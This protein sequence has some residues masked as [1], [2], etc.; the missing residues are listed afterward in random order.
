MVNFL[1]GIDE[2]IKKL[3]SSRQTIALTGAGISTASGI[4]DFRS[5]H[6]LWNKYNPSKYANINS[7]KENPSMVWELALILFDLTNKS[8]PNNAHY[9]LADLEKAG[10]LH[11][12]ITQNIDN[13]HQRAGS[14]NVIDY[15]GSIEQA[16]CPACHITAAITGLTVP[17]CSGCG[18]IMKPA[19]TLFGE[20]VPPAAFL[21][22]R[23]LAS[24]SDV[25][26]VIGTSAV[27]QPAA[28]LPFIA[29]EHGAYIIE[30]NSEE[31][32]LTNY[33]TGCFIKGPVEETLPDLL[34]KLKI[35]KE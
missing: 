6:G 20:N 3:L 12:L 28:D 16:V 14:R 26:M 11:G 19:F 17:V 5:E 9:A 15:H 35:Y 27:V 2:A 21:E 22:A 10:L 32:G 13:L 33:I 1:Y 4:P 34:L 7:F 24:F 23:N 18:R 31:T 8:N 29:R 30:L 25:F